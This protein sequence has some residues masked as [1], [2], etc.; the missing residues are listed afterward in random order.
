MLA[1]YQA[2]RASPLRSPPG[3]ATGR[4]G[5]RPVITVVEPSAARAHFEVRE[6]FREARNEKTM[7]MPTAQ[8]MAYQRS[9]PGLVP[10]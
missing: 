3:R 10:V 8:P 9:A 6:Y 7:V 2:R 5:G 1:T 4:P